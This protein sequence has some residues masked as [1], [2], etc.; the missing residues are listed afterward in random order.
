MAAR[1]RFPRQHVLTEDEREKFYA[2]IEGNAEIIGS[3]IRQH[4]SHQM[5]EN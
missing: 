1:G 3:L 2:V 4:Y 5:L